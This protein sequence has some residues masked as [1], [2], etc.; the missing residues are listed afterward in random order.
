MTEDEEGYSCN[1]A[2]AHFATVVFVVVNILSDGGTDCNICNRELMNPEIGDYNI[3]RD[4]I[5]IKFPRECGGFI[6]K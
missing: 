2:V 1:P 3:K 6:T 4:S 5:I